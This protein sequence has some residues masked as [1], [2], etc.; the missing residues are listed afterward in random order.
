MHGGECVKWLQSNCLGTLPWMPLPVAFFLT[1]STYGTRLHGD[2]RGSV[3]R[4]HNIPGTPLLDPDPV[5]VDVEETLLAHE[6]IYLSEQSRRVVTKAVADHAE[7]RKWTVH[8]VNDRTNHV[9]VVIDCRGENFRSPERVLT[10]L[11]SWATRRLRDAKLVR[12]DGPI[13]TYHGST[14]WINE[15]GGLPEAVEYVRNCQ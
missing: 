10:E 6:P 15:D 7:F 5:R 12:S 11:K 14:R 8:A 4:W 13:W 1:W 3:S 2:E 9:H